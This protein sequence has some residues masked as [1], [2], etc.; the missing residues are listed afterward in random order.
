MELVWKF[1][2]T[3]AVCYLAGEAYFGN[4]RGQIRRIEDAFLP[5]IS[6]RRGLLAGSVVVVLFGLWK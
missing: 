1:V 4:L 2:E 5:K 3:A 6:L